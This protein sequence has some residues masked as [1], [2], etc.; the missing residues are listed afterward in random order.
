MIDRGPEGASA[1]RSHSPGNLARR[2]EVTAL[3]LAR[4]GA[5]SPFQAEGLIQRIPLGG[6]S[7]GSLS[8][9]GALPERAFNLQGKTAMTGNHDD[10][11][12]TVQP[13]DQKMSG[14]GEASFI[15]PRAA[16]P[17]C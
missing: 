2:V 17:R 11:R 12:E 5:A 6:R 3:A 8:G 7:I 9:A 10:L 1:F 16:T 14:A 4:L 15:R 13:G